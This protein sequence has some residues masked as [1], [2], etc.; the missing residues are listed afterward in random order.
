MQLYCFPNICVCEILGLTEKQAATASHKVNDL[1]SRHAL[2]N[3]NTCE[4]FPLTKNLHQELHLH[5]FSIP[6]KTAGAVR[7]KRGYTPQRPWDTGTDKGFIPGTDYR[8]FSPFS[9]TRLRSDGWRWMNSIIHTVISSW[10]CRDRSGSR[11]GV[12]LYHS[13]PSKSRCESEAVQEYS[14][15][16]AHTH[17]HTH[18][19]TTG[20]VPLCWRT[21]MTL[22]PH[23]QLISF[24]FGYRIVK[25]L[26]FEP[27]VTE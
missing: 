4:K 23:S 22:S 27:S 2:P 21:V 17:T 10:R 9:L 18:N 6:W 25:I 8:F 13:A 5:V 1:P 14:P 19:L 12:R 24:L 7:L 20:H 3:E 26:I 16:D 15:Q 11:M